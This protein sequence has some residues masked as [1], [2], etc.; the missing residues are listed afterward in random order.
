MRLCSVLFVSADTGDQF[1]EIIATELPVEP[2]S[3]LVVSDLERGE[4]IFDL[5]E[6]GEVVR[7]HDFALHNGEVDLALIEP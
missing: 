5:V 3:S 6:R 1:V 7:V 2:D 4:A